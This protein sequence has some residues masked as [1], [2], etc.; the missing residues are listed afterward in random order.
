MNKVEFKKRISYV[1]IELL[2]TISLAF[3]IVA[4]AFPIFIK[5]LEMFVG[6][7]GYTLH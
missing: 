2:K 1:G 4:I 6:L 5:L 7:F 3:L